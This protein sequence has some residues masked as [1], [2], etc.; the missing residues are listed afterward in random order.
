M[1]AHARLN[2]KAAGKPLSYVP[3]V[4]VPV[5]RMT[6]EVFDEMGRSAEH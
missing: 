6:R 4:D 5:V 2:A 3:S 1:N